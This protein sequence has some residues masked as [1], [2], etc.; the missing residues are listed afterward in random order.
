VGLPRPQDRPLN[1]G[2]AP[3]RAENL[4]DLLLT[5]R[6]MELPQHT[7]AISFAGNGFVDSRPR[8]ALLTGQAKFL[9]VRNVETTNAPL[10]LVPSDFDL[11]YSSDEPA[12]ADFWFEGPRGG[13][14][15]EAY[16]QGC[17][18]AVT[19]ADDATLDEVFDEVMANAGT[20]DS[21]SRQVR[22]WRDSDD[23]PQWDVRRLSSPPWGELKRNYPISTRQ[24]LDD[25]ML[26]GPPESSARLLLWHGEPGTGKTSAVLGLIDA[27]HDWCHAQ[28]ISDPERM[29]SDANYLLSVMGHTPGP[30]LTGIDV[31]KPRTP[32]WKLIVCEDADE[33]LR[34]DA[35][36]RSGPALGRLLNATDGLLGRGSNT[37]V[38]LTTNDELGRLHPAVTRPGRCLS[39]LE[40]PRFNSFEASSWL[41]RPSQSATLAEL[42]QS[43]ATG[44]DAEPPLAIGVYL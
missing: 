19:A 23:G 1:S 20:P 24:A 16:A 15:L 22:I 31:T 35:R 8:T 21:R 4:S 40:F 12:C 26:A 28:V 44:V 18:V 36:A 10:S 6:D 11:K 34:S 17:R 14:L 3:G 13:F 42:Y 27:W 39:S 41:G 32:R 30:E 38:L 33:Y 29:F 37:L 2:H 9:R 25:L 43:R 5:L 7:T